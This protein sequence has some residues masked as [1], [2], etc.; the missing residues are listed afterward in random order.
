MV[1]HTA[2]AVL[3]QGVI[4]ELYHLFHHLENLNFSDDEILQ[5][6]K[7]Y[8]KKYDLCYFYSENIYHDIFICTKNYYNINTRFFEHID[9]DINNLSIDLESIYMLEHVYE[10]FYKYMCGQ[11]VEYILEPKLMLYSYIN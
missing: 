9:V 4:I 7:I 5:K 11:N 2:Y 6:L 8:L 10:N 1:K 3:A